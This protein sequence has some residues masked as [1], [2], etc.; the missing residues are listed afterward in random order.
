MPLD[1]EILLC[2]CMAGFDNTRRFA[3]LNES[4]LTY[5]IVQRAPGGRSQV[6]RRHVASLREARAR[7][8]V[9]EPGGARRC[10]SDATDAAWADRAR[11]RA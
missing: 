7:A 11:S 8:C 1:P 3:V 6:L 2:D 9:T 5:D 4:T 10:E